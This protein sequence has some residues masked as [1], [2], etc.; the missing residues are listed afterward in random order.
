VAPRALIDEGL[1]SVPGV[2]TVEVMTIHE[3]ISVMAS[4]SAVFVAL[5]GG[6]GTLEELAVVLSM[7]ALGDICTPCG[8][9][10]AGGFFSSF[11]EQVETLE[12]E[13]FI[14]ADQGT[15]LLVGDTAAELLPRLLKARLR[16][17]R[18]WM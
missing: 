16:P 14:R 18:K 8:L 10:N 4:L 1:P 9:V 6:Y 5:P 2:Q 13:G 12:A 7:Q 3:R 15:G 11:V 17:S